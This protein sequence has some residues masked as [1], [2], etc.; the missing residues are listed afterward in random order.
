M[1]LPLL[2]P[3]EKELKHDRIAGLKHDFEY[4]GWYIG[5]FN[6]MIRL[7]F[8]GYDVVEFQLTVRC[9]KIDLSATR[10]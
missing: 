4:F 5:R 1:F 10:N 6:P 3:R 2:Q 9:A 7:R 8:N